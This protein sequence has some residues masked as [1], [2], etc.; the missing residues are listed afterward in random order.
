MAPTTHITPRTEAVQFADLNTVTAMEL[1]GLA[2][3]VANDLL[4]GEFVKLWE[5]QPG[6]GYGPV[7]SDDEQIMLTRVKPSA[8]FLAKGNY[9]CTKTVTSNL[10]AVGYVA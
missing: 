9:K 8:V 1:D 2:K 5:E 3:I 4:E 10:T 7:M 6:G